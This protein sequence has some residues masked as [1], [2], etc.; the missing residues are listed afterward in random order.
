VHISDRELA[1]LRRSVGP[2]TTTEKIRVATAPFSADVAEFTGNPLRSRIPS[3]TY[4]IGGVTW[5]RDGTGSPL[6]S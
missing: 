4:R 6:K 1:N 5:R 3:I 2:G